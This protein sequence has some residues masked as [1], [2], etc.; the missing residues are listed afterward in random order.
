MPELLAIPGTIQLVLWFI[1]VGMQAFAFADAAMRPAEAFPAVNKQTKIF[2][3]I[4]LGLAIGVSIMYM[5]QVLGLLPIVGAVAAAVYLAGV[6]PAVK[7]IT[8]GRSNEGP[9]GP[10]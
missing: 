6:R 8:Q 1:V 10:W 9:Y 5:P 4:I 7:E 3:L 2:W